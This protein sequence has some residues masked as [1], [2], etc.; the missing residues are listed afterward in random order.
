MSEKNI[1]SFLKAI[2]WRI[3]GT[4]ATIIISY[5]LTKKID[6]SCLIGGFDFIFKLIMYY[7]HERIWNRIK[8]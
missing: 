7:L 2:T 8:I 5:V 4:I 3:G 6:I 1:R